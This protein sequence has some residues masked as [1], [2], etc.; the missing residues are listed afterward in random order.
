MITIEA[1]VNLLGAIILVLVLIAGAV[2]IAHLALWLE[3]R[4][5]LWRKS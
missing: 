2:L 5:K 1:I 4:R 3:H